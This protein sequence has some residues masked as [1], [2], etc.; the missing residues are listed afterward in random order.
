MGALMKL[1]SHATTKSKQLWQSRQPVR[2]DDKIRTN[3]NA[4]LA[5][6]ELNQNNSSVCKIR[7]IHEYV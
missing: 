7:T 2:K 1:G 3:I 5:A 4:Q 6:Q